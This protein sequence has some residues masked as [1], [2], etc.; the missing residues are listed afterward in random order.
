MG[1]Q[2]RDKFEGGAY[3]SESCPSLVALPQDTC[4]VTIKLKDEILTYLLKVLVSEKVVGIVLVQQRS[5]ITTFVPKRL[6]AR[7]MLEVSLVNC[8][9]QSYAS[10]SLQ[11]AT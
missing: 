3:A 5:N 1:E 11:S 9:F 7:A 10:K 6:A 2:F 4:P 8:G